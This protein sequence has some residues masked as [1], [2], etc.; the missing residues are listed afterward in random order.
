MTTETKTTCDGCGKDCLKHKFFSSV[1]IVQGSDADVPNICRHA[2]S[3]AC[4][5]TIL[6]KTVQTLDATLDATSGAT[7]GAS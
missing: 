4:V 7:S 2:C 1:L 3:S 5:V 6:R